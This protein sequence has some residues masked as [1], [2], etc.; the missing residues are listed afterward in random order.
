MKTGF[1]V[2]IIFILL[3]G[4]GFWFWLVRPKAAAASQSENKEAPA[5]EVQ[6]AA[7]ARK[8]IS[9]NETAY[10]TVVAQ[11]GKI[12]SMSV[13][14]EVRVRHVLV[15]SGQT[16]R[17]NEKLI[18]IE[19]SLG[20]E[21]QYRQAQNAADAA[22]RDLAEI[23]SK[24]NVKL[25]TNSELGQARKASKDADL[26]L[27]SLVNAGVETLR[28]IHAQGSPESALVD[29][30]VVQDG[31]IVGAGGPLVELIDADDIEVKL[32]IKSESI[33]RMK[34]GLPVSLLPLGTD[35]E[36]PIAGIVRMVTHRVDPITQ[37][38]NVFVSVQ[39]G[40]NLIIDSHVQANVQIAAH[41]T[42][43]V[44]KSAV[45]P[46]GTEFSLFTVEEGKAK[47]QVVKVG[48]ATAAEVEIAGVD[49]KE[50]DEVVTVGNYELKDGV[51]VE[52]QKDE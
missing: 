16:L 46:K 22:R 47:E 38:V 10:G 6:V 12:Q 28:E 37:L 29:K 43:V 20:T 23:Q 17:A 3:V 14:F 24:F 31:Q 2:F 15:A 34:P 19:P 7:V 52:V 32:G 26:Q 41:E 8:Q 11:P 1:L 18:E 39:P 33:D 30:V 35:S 5:A 25:A 21:L 36:K 27:A 45:L 44:P 49:L 42:L 50:G 13:P 40:T 48:I 4:A 9:E 51:P